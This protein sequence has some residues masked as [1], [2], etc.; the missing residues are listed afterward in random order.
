MVIGINGCSSNPNYNRAASCGDATP[1]C[2][3]VVAAVDMATYDKQNSQ[4]CSD[5][6]GE[7][8][9]ECIAQSEILKKHIKDASEK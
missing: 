7:R 9:K 1:L 8:K 3:G 2:L 4:R 6:A 5:L